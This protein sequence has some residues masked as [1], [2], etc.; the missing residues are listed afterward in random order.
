MRPVVVILQHEPKDT[1][2]YMEAYLIKR[3]IDYVT[4]ECWNDDVARC[5]PSSVASHIRCVKRGDGAH[6]FSP[7]P[8]NSEEGECCCIR[9]VVSFGGSMS[10][11]DDLPYYAPVLALMRSCIETRTP[12]LGHCLGGQLLARCLGGSVRASEHVEVGWMDQE[13]VNADAGGIKD[14]FGGRQ[15]INVFQIHTESFTVPAGARLVVK[16]KYC[17]NQAYQVGDQYALGMQFH[18]E[19]DEEKVRALTST[20]FPSL[21]TRAEIGAMGDE[22]AARLSPAAMTR[23]EIERCLSEGRVERNWP[24]ADSIYDTWCSGFLI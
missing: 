3:G 14:W 22:E 13:V 15:V 11:N 7:L 21:H 16:G 1:A 5:L 10:A 2:A 12:V 6:R 18:P 20:E 4:Y 24:I 8:N 23:D 9:G 19:V 17:A